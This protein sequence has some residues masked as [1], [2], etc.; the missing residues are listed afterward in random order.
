MSENWKSNCPAH[1]L[2]HFEKVPTLPW[3]VYDD[4]GGRIHYSEAVRNRLM[5]MCEGVKPPK[6]YPKDKRP[7]WQEEMVIQIEKMIGP[8]G[9]MMPNPGCKELLLQGTAFHLI[10]VGGD[11]YFTHEELVP[12]EW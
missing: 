6:R 4:Q 9:I 10:R 7:L 8:L 3:L 2:S 11:L 12:Y 1:I 5:A